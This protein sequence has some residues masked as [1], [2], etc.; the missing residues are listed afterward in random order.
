MIKG[1]TKSGFQFELE[2]DIVDDYDLVLLFGKYNKEP[3]MDVFSE[4]AVKMLGEEQHQ[5]LMEFVRDEKGR[6]KTSAM[7]SALKEIEESLPAL[8]NSEPSPT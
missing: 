6:C 3:S 5:A 2:D 4:I 8:K 1:T 7:L